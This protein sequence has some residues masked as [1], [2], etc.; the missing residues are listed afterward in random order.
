MPNAKSLG[1]KDVFKEKQFL[2]RPAEEK[3]SAIS[4]SDGNHSRKMLSWEY[5]ARFMTCM[6]Y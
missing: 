1:K 3:F 4:Q 5:E 6:Q 2:V